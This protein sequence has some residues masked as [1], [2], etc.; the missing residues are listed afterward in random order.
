MQEHLLVTSSSVLSALFILSIIAGIMIG[1]G[2]LVN[3]SIGGVAGAIVFSVG[4]LTI[5]YYQFALF[6]G[7]AGLF[8]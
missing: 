6:T 3:L 5:I 8:I 1:I 4:L 7:K 2:G